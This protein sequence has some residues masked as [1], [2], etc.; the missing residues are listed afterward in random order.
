MGVRRHPTAALMGFVHQRLHLLKGVLLLA[1]VG[2]L[3]QHP[4]GGAE[5]HHVSAIL[6][7]FSYLGAHRPRPVGN[8]TGAVLIT[9]RQQIVVAVTTGDTERRSRDTKPRAD[10]LAVVDGVAQGDIGI[11]FGADVAYRR[12]PRLDRLLGVEGAIERGPW[13]RDPETAVAMEPMVT[14]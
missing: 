6:D 9:R 14:G 8:T 11:P 7:H 12:K 1:D 3:R 2:A 5:L 4:A 10:D 13:H